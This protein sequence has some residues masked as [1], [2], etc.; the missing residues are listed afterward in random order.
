MIAATT[1]GQRPRNHMSPDV[2]ICVDLTGDTVTA[3]VRGR[4]DFVTVG[5]V[6]DRLLEIA[7]SGVRALVVD[8]TDSELRDPTG[9][10]ALLHV[11]DVCRIRNV[12]FSVAVQ[13]GSQAQDA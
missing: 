1:P 3:H 4:V 9:P 12:L 2:S 6:R 7:R 8:L 10:A 5:P 13:H 11:H